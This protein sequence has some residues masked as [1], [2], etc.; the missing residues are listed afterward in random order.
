LAVKPKEGGPEHPPANV[1]STSVTNVAA[2]GATVGAG[3]LTIQNPSGVTESI[4]SASINVSHPGLFSTMT[5]SGAGQ[6]V[7][8]TSPSAT[9]KFT[10]TTPISIPAGGSVTFS[11]NAVIA[12]HPV[13]LGSEIKYAGLTPT[14]SLPI[15]TSTWPLTGGLL[16]LGVAL[17]GLP[18]STRRRVIIFAVLGLGLAAASAGCGGGSNGPIPVSSTQQVTAVAISAEGASATVKGLPANLGTITDL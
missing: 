16:M 13:M 3:T 9:T 17:L 7:T 2:P 4:A 1:T 18:N 12:M 6:S 15:T 10:F 11:V 8:V 5:L 14:K